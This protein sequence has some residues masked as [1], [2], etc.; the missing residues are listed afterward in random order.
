MAI[1]DKEEIKEFRA[2]IKRLRASDVI[3]EQTAINGE[4]FITGAS[5]I[6]HYGKEL[7][8]V[9]KT[10]LSKDLD[11]LVEQ[12]YISQKWGDVRKVAKLGLTP[13]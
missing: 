5:P 13:A 4:N 8:D 11:L 12:K 7:S 3:T 1:K 10:Q 9:E 6:H 2:A